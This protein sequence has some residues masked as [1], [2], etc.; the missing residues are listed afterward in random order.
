MGKPIKGL[1]KDSLPIDQPSQT[2]RDA[3]NINLNDNVGS[4]STEEGFAIQESLPTGAFPLHYDITPDKRLIIFYVTDSTSAIGVYKDGEFTTVLDDSDLSFSRTV[5]IQSTVK[6]DNSGNALV[7]WT[8]DENPPRVYNIDTQESYADINELNIFDFITDV[9][10]ISLDT[11]ASSGGSLFSGSYMFALRYIDEDD[12]RSNYFSITRPIPVLPNSV[13]GFVQGL[14]TVRTSKII[15]LNISN[16]DT[17]YKELEVAVIRFEE[18]SIAETIS[19]PLIPISGSSTTISYGGYGGTPNSL[20]EITINKVSYTRA[21]AIGQ[22]DNVLY[23]GNLQRDSEVDYQKYANNIKTYAIT[24]ESSADNL[25]DETFVFKNKS[26]RRGEVYAFYISFILDDGTETEAFHIPGREAVGTEKNDVT[27]GSIAESING[28]AKRFHFFPEKDA[29]YGM[30]YWENDINEDS[31]PDNPKFDIVDI[32]ASGNESQVGTLRNKA[33]RHHRFPDEFDE[34]ILSNT[35]NADP[36]DVSL[37]GVQ[38]Y[39]VKLPSSLKDKVKGVK[40]YY[41]SKNNSNRLIID[42]GFSIPQQTVSSSNWDIIDETV[43]R[44]LDIEAQWTGQTWTDFSFSPFSSMLNKQN[45]ANV[46]YLVRTRKGKTSKVARIGQYDF[47]YQVDKRVPLTSADRE[48]SLIDVNAISYYN[49]NLP[50]VNIQDL[51]FPNNKSSYLEPSGIVIESNNNIGVTFDANLSAY[52]ESPT[53]QPLYREFGAIFKM[54]TFRDYVHAPFTQ[55][56]L[57]V[58]GKVDTDID[59]FD[60]TVI[61]SANRSIQLYSGDTFISNY[62]QLVSFDRSSGEDNLNQA[63]VRTIVQSYDHSNWRQ[64]GEGEF[65]FNVNNP[66]V[67]EDVLDAYRNASVDEFYDNYYAYD[68]A[69]SVQAY[70]KATVPDQSEDVLRKSIPTRIIRSAEENFDTQQD[71]FRTFLENDYLDIPSSK[72]QINR[73]ASNNGVLVIHT[74]SALFRTRGKEQLVTGD[75]RAFLGSGDIFEVQPTELFNTKY[76]FAGIQDVS[77]SIETPIGYFFVDSDNKS[78]YM[79]SDKINDLTE[80]GMRNFFRENLTWYIDAA[81]SHKNIPFTKIVAEF[82]PEYNRILLTK[83]DY[84]P[85]DKFFT[86]QNQGLIS[87]NNTTGMFENQGTPIPYVENV[88]FED[89]SFTLSYLPEINAWASF[90]D[91]KPL[92]YMNNGIDLFSFKDEDIYKHN[93]PTANYTD[94]YGTEHGMSLQVVDNREPTISK[95]LVNIEFITSVIQDGKEIWNETFDRFRITNSVQ[96]SDIQSLVYFTNAGGNLRNIEGSWRV[97]KFRDM[98]DANG[99]IPE[100]DIPWYNQ[101]KFIG[102]YAIIDLYYDTPEDKKLALTDITANFKQSIR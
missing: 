34:P 11:V 33:V 83:K 58:L 78:V 73:I 4:I 92:F 54:C 62:S 49:S 90:H 86:D 100:T 9:G 17:S 95:Q 72:G 1:Y 45:I 8:D 74:E 7:Y 99:N 12:N 16:L 43:F 60:P 91:Y 23:M 101:K 71:N 18:N 14:Q 76:G 61:G 48:A 19:L 67:K 24:K 5:D 53:L 30:A 35:E 79:L 25:D 63:I 22:L 75:F 55:E 28:G 38:F 69:Y 31:Y 89:K 77:S 15:K 84:K 88:Y 32:D 96:D 80:L 20:D 82:D 13:S 51:G 46:D 37:V 2:Y 26:F 70:L 102:K 6:L 97:N 87:F 57:C 36:I 50:V 98:T 47:E 27:T 3:K 68:N 10:S 59:K 52:S 39:D 21:K 94:Y 42:E 29:T 66:E 41:A 93:V 81:E 64:P 56:N 44:N 40:F 65:E 85:K